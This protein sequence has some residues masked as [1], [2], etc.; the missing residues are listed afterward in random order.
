MFFLFKPK[1][2]WSNF[3]PSRLCFMFEWL[4]YIKRVSFRLSK[5][6]QTFHFKCLQH[7]ATVVQID[8]FWTRKYNFCDPTCT[9]IIIDGNFF[10]YK[11]TSYTY[12]ILR[13]I[14]NKFFEFFNHVIMTSQITQFV[15]KIPILCMSLRENGTRYKV[16]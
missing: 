5:N 8:A 16:E 3:R 13:K 10:R 12:A 1:C 9:L 2:F 7:G 14:H 4:G 15:H 6:Y 11:N